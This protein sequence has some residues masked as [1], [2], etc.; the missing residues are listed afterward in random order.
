[1]TITRPAEPGGQLRG[2][3]DEVWIHSLYVNR[4]IGSFDRRT[5]LALGTSSKIAAAASSSCRRP[6]PTLVR[7]AGC[8]SWVPTRPA[9]RRHRPSTAAWTAQQ[10]R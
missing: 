2:P 10:L 3:A 7:T 4:Q 8:R 9:H 1:L 5:H 6:R